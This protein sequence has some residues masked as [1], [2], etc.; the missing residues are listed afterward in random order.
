[1]VAKLLG[2][3]DDTRPFA[4]LW[5]GSHPSGSAVI[6]DQAGLP[7]RDW[8]TCNSVSALGPDLSA[9]TNELP[10]LLKV[11]SV[12]QP[13]SIQAHPDAALAKKLHSEHPEHY[14]DPRHKPEMGIAL[15]QVDLLCGFKTRDELLNTFARYPALL[16]LIPKVVAEE[17]RF[18]SSS[19]SEE[20]LRSIAYR[21]IVQAPASDRAST[22][23][24]IAARVADRS[25]QSRFEKIIPSLIAEYGA[26]DIGIASGLLLK[27]LNL[28]PGEAL[29]I[30]PRIPHAYLHGDLIE[31]MA[32]SDN[33]VRG[34]LTRKFQDKETLIE[35]LDYRCSDS[36]I[37]HPEDDPHSH[38]TE[39]FSPPVAD[40]QV[41]IMSGSSDGKRLVS[42]SGPQLL[43]Q[44]EGVAIVI[45]P[46]GPAITLT[47]GQGLFVPAVHESYDVD[48]K[49]G[50]SIRVTIGRRGKTKSEDTSS[51]L[52][53]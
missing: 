16:N 29:Y 5:V 46:N 35:M 11:L 32:A 41:A 19:L 1:M 23:S 26:D 21:S 27:E 43:F 8:I 7:L 49:K 6:D 31:C 10:F 53:Q 45:F 37:I 28:M 9:Q 20:G 33:V 39:Y 4:E 2:A 12:D 18:G 3:T 34:G 47:P 30:A 40:F 24:D 48:L 25:D 52:S 42:A 15:T 22:T 17:I 38:H 44:L 36:G 51:G 14:P 13:L 50:R